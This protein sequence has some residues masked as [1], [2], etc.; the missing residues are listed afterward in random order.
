MLAIVGYAMS[1]MDEKKKHGGGSSPNASSTRAAA[2]VA[3]DAITVSSD[4][5]QKD[6]SA[7]EVNADNLYRGHL[8]RV[9]GAVQA[10]KKDFMDDVYVV[11]WTTNEFEG[12]HAN[13]KGDGNGLAGVSPGDHIAVRCRGDNVIMGSPM[14]KDCILDQ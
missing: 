2:E 12:V 5:L 7:N 4:R 10:V 8:L 14:L 13:F 11:L 6:Y 9:T 1:A 3:E